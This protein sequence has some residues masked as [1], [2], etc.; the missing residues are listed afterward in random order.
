M[1]HPPVLAQIDGYLASEESL[2]S[3]AQQLAGCVRQ[4]SGSTASNAVRFRIHLVGDLGTGK[5]S[6]ARAFLRACGVTGRI[7]SPS[8]ALLESYN[9]SSLYFYH[10]DFYRFTDP[11]E[12]LDAG[13]RDIFQE[14]AVIL[15]E[16]PDKAGSLLPPPDIEIRLHY[17][18]PGRQAQLI[19]YSNKGKLWLTSITLPPADAPTHS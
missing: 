1:S 5:T 12:W 8:Y 4:A 6:F 7:K 3:L 10:F 9:V 15:V 18:L 17:A 14:D 11:S 19:A 16:W 13:F 2:E